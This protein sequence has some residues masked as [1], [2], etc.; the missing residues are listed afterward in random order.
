[1]SSDSAILAM[2]HQV[3]HSFPTF[4][5]Q[6]LKHIQDGTLYVADC[7]NRRVVRVGPDVEVF[8]E[9]ALGVFHGF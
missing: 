1:M 5:H 2:F 4:S 9:A 3:N 6:R 7:G 8:G